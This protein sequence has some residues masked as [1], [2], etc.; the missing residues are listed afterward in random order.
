MDLD[1]YQNHARA[2]LDRLRAQCVERG[3]ALAP[4]TASS[5]V[6]NEAL[7]RA[8]AFNPDQAKRSGGV[9]DYDVALSEFSSALYNLMLNYAIRAL[10]KDAFDHF[11]LA[12]RLQQG[13]RPE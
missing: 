6:T 5:A 8:D 1:T 12:L 3:I 13:A 4:G 2:I 7:L 10:P 11:P 9:N